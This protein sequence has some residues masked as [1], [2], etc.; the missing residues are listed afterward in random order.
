MPVNSLT[1]SFLLFTRKYK[2]AVS[3]TRK[4]VILFAELLLAYAL[5]TMLHPTPNKGQSIRG[6]SRIC[7]ALS[8]VTS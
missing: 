6:I 7:L 4:E 2:K 3:C 5:N 1:A 8:A